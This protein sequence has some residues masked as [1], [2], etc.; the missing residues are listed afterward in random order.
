MRLMYPEFILG[1]TQIANEIGENIVC[2][3]RTLP[4]HNIY[5]Q[6]KL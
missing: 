3:E 5:H 6:I 2:G 1:L 4:T